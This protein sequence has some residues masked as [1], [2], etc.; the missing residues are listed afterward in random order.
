[1]IKIVALILVLLV[2]TVLVAA[3]SRPDTF[4]V[5]R[6]VRI[7]AVPEK[8]FPLINDFHRWEAWSPWEK[9]DPQVRRS[10]GGQG[11]GVGAA[12]EWSGNKELGRGRMEIIEASA[13]SRLMIQIDFFAPFEAHNKVEFTLAPDGDT[14]VVTHAMF[15][16][17][18]FFFKLMGLVFSMDK[19]VGGKFA[20]GLASLKALAE[21]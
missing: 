6:S 3:A 7:K 19:M 20:E 12:Y 5:E 18:S 14:T 8:I 1:M 17:S 9:V 21:K 15:G 13:P 2:V 4:R 10:Y 11:S 16:P